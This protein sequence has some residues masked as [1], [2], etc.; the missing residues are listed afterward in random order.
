M[1]ANTNIN[2]HPLKCKEKMQGSKIFLRVSKRVRSSYSLPAPEEPLYHFISWPNLVPVLPG[3]DGCAR[4]TPL[5]QRVGLRIA[6]GFILCYEWVHSWITSLFPKKMRLS[7]LWFESKDEA[8]GEGSG[9]D[10]Q[11]WGIY[12]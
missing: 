4:R 5:F 9:R 3:P 10:H 2:L 11:A 8:N 7:Y 6:L 12:S 1:S